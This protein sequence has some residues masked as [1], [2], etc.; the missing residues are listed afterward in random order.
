MILRP[1]RTDDIPKLLAIHAESRAKYGM[2]ALDD[3]NVLEAMVAVDEEDNPRVL[4]TA[5]RVAE[6]VLVMDHT[7]ET[8]AYRAVALGELVKEMRDRL[9]SKD[10]NS[11]YA[12]LGPDV[13]RSY[14]RRLWKLGARAMDWKCVK[15]IRGDV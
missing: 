9:L 4:L 12:F 11:S 3:V 15:W 5:E 6:L 7:W 1:M 8:P 14:E 2:P 13:P 10:L